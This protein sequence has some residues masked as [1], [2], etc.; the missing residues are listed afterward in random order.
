LTGYYLIYTSFDAACTNF[1]EVFS[2]LLLLWSFFLSVLIVLVSFFAAELDS[3]HLLLELTESAEF[4][5]FR[6]PEPSVK[7]DLKPTPEPWLR[8]RLRDQ[9]AF[10]STFCTSVFMLSVISV[11]YML[12]WSNGPPGSHVQKNHPS[13]FQ[14]PGFVSE[15]VS[16]LGVT[17]AAMKVSQ[18]PWIV[19]PLGVVP[20]G[21]DKLRLI[22][23]LRFVNSFLKIDSFK[24]ESLKMVPHL[25]KIKDLLF[26]VDLKS[27]YHHVDIHP[28]Y[29]RF[30]GFE[31]EGQYYVFCQLPFG[32]ATACFV[33]SKIVKQLVQH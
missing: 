27:T 24:Y 6:K 3:L 19:S 13:A 11:G 4:E 18:R 22:L 26:S 23:D 25:C 32:L 7:S 17:G 16:I 21:V 30:L 8:N 20:K 10:R 14:H 31:W 28:D 1:F 12:P 2:F 9:K 5:G 15:A 29:W 33:F